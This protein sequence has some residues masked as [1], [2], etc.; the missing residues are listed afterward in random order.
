MGSFDANSFQPLAL[1]YL[2]GADENWLTGLAIDRSGSPLVVGFADHRIVGR[3]PFPRTEFATA[4][5]TRFRTGAVM[6]ISRM[7]PDLDRLIDSTWL[8]GSGMAMARAVGLDGTD[9]V[10]VTGSTSSPDFPGTRDWTTDCGPRGNEELGV[11]LRLSR[12]LSHVEGVALFGEVLA[13]SLIDF[14]TRAVCLFNSGSFSF[15]RGIATG[16]L[17]TLIGGPF[18]E[19]DTLDVRGVQAPILY[20]SESQ[21]NFVL[22]REA[23]TGSNLALALSG[24]IVRRMDISGTKPTWM[25]NLLEIGPSAGFQ[26]SSINARRPDGTLNERANRFLPGE[27]IRAYATAIDLNLPLKLLVSYDRTE[28]GAFKASYVPGS[29]DSVVEFRFE[30]R[31]AFGLIIVNGGVD[32]SSGFLW[33]DQ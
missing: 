26:I 25:Y 33:L 27:E 17:V 5:L 23:G 20:R 18:S 3:E 32:S 13:P 8:A 1:S 4:P 30:N 24:K 12:S 10:I 11:G 28:F 21:V 7:S 15:R 16:L 6:T 22:P 14:D 29:F 31:G 9:R 19:L 2:G